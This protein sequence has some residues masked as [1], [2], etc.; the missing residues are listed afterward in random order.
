VALD[1]LAGLGTLLGAGE[2]E[3][4]ERAL[5]LLIF[6]LHHSASSHETKN[7]AARLFAEMEVE[8]PPQVVSAAQERGQANTLKAVVKEILGESQ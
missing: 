4:M 7:K 6:V 3:Q 1:A 2:Q 8:L 5:G